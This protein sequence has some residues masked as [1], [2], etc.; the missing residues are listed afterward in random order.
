LA[1]TF[2][3]LGGA[4][5]AFTH[6]S[7]GSAPGAAEDILPRPDAGAV[8]GRALIHFALTGPFA[9]FEAV[10]AAAFPPA[11]AAALSGE[12]SEALRGLAGA[13]GAPAGAG[14]V[15]L[16]TGLSATASARTVF[17]RAPELF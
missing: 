12:R 13:G 5:G 4:K 6:W 10:A 16:A 11:C 7:S 9:D 14:F 15:G 17:V 8:E 2:G 1:G 3:A